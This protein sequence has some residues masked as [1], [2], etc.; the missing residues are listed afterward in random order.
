VDTFLAIASKRDWRRFAER[1]IPPEVER[2]ILEAGRVS[3][4]ASNRQHRRFVVVADPAFKTRVAEILYAPD[5][6]RAAALVVAVVTPAGEMPAMDAGRAIENMFLAAW[7][8][9]VASVP[10]GVRDRAAAGALF[11]LGDDEVVRIVLAFGYPRRPRDPESRPPEE[12]L[13][14]AN[15]K[16]FDEVVERR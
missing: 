6:V 1:P 10:N 12:W 7:N 4:S 16:P 14:D 2:R 5:N 9:G 13:A 15:R 3:S 11:G 8:E